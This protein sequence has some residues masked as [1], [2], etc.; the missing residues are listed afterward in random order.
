MESENGS[1]SSAQVNGRSWWNYSSRK[2]PNLLPKKFKHLWYIITWPSQAYRKFEWWCISKFLKTKVVRNE[3]VSF[4]LHEMNRLEPNLSLLYYFKDLALTTDVEETVQVE[5]N[6]VKQMIQAG[7]DIHACDDLG[8]NLMHEIARYHQAEVCYFFLKCKIDINLGTDFSVTP[9]HVAAA[10]NNSAVV[11]I[12]ASNGG[13]VEATTFYMLQ[14]PLHYAARYDSPSSVKKLIEMGAHLEARDY[15]G[16]TPLLLAAELG[17][18]SAGAMLLECGAKVYAIDYTGMYGISAMVEKCPPLAL[19]ALDMCMEKDLRNRKQYYSLQF[20]EPTTLC[21]GKSARTT[22]TVLEEAVRAGSQNLAIIKHDMIQKIID[23]KWKQ[24]GRRGYIKEL[25]AYIIV[26]INWSLLCLFNPIRHPYPDHEEVE[27]G[28]IWYIE[29][30]NEVLTVVFYFYQVFDEIRELRTNMRRHEK[31]VQQRLKQ[32][33]MEFKY[34]ELLSEEEKEYLRK[35]QETVRK[36]ISAYSG[37][38]WNTFDWFSIVMMLATLCAHFPIKYHE[39]YAKEYSIEKGILLSITLVIVWLK[40]FKYC[41]VLEMLGPFCV[42]IASLPMD[43]VKI[44]I[45]YIILYAPMACLFYHF[46]SCPYNDLGFEADPCNPDTKDFDPGPDVEFDYKLYGTFEETCFTVFLYTLVGDYGYDTL[47]FISSQRLATGEAK[48]FTF[49]KLCIAYWIL[50]SAV[51]LLNIF[52]ALMS[53]TFSKVYENA[54]V[55]SQF[56]RAAM[57]VSIENKLPS[58]WRKHHL[59][60]I[61]YNYSPHVDFYDDDDVHEENPDQFEKEV[62]K[63]DEIVKSLVTKARVRKEN[64]F[65]T[66]AKQKLQTQSELIEGILEKIAQKEAFMEEDDD[67]KDS[68]GIR[69]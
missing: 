32:L 46:F 60:D 34:L 51:L 67:E 8:Q 11:E 17:R 22:F 20:L 53:E 26:L 19:K 48:F 58:Y 43:F 31:F 35:E 3:R 55:V 37:D 4:Q 40:M 29:I 57:I 68:V 62:R 27:K 64:D 7:A 18:M 56:E 36:S 12:L 9:L 44:A 30:A 69:M 23:V 63:T 25:A 5:M 59:I 54:L 45:V 6:I 39:P 10:F 13:F 28:A 21:N 47:K 24:F 33:E 2:N 65:Q 41:R 1:C 38:Y 14:T 42:I 50:V 16:R 52:I 15:R 49:T 61:A 66:F